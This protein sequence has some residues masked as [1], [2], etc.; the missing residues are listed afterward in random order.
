MSFQVPVTFRGKADSCE[1]T[2]VFLD[3]LEDNS[4]FPQDG[5]PFRQ[6]YSGKM[7][8]SSQGNWAVRKRLSG[9][10]TSTQ[11]KHKCTTSGTLRAVACMEHNFF[12]NKMWP[13]QVSDCFPL[14][15]PV[16][17]EA[18][19]RAEVEVVAQRRN[20]WDHDYVTEV[21][22]KKNGERVPGVFQAPAKVFGWGQDPSPPC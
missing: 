21:A 12:E 4:N 14:G 18:G 8:R 15:G 5:W 19:D 16:T 20:M 2:D 9:T 10:G 13:N 17:F 6:P 1:D 3:V 7:C 22:W 11:E